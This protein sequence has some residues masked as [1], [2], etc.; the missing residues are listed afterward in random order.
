MFVASPLFS[1]Y[2]SGEDWPQKTV[3]IVVG[4]GP[5][6]S[7]DVMARHLAKSM[8]KYIKH[9]VIVI[10]KTGGDATLNDAYVK[11]QPADGLHLAS[12]TTTFTLNLQR[13]DVD[14]SVSDFLLVSRIHLDPFVF[15]VR[16]GG[17]YKT[18][19]D[20]VKDAKEKLGRLTV[21]GFTSIGGQRVAQI[22]FEKEA[23]IKCKWMAFKAGPEAIVTLMGGNAD[24]VM[25]NA[26][27]IR[28]YKDKVK[29]VAH[30]SEKPL[31]LAPDI[32]SFKQLGYS[33]ELTRYHWRGLVVRA[34][35]PQPIVEKVH[36]LITKA[37][38]DSEFAEFTKKQ[39]LIDGYLPLDKLKEF[40]QINAKKDK[41]VLKLLNVEVK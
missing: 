7:F 31:I 20:F 18:L 19:D 9:P 37:T 12:E 3:T 29:A 21:A 26:D 41:E 28:Q 13:K 17:P 1:A 14:M 15:F 10:N 27:Y 2:G 16:E 33:N 39:G 34:E 30:T 22:L 8:E 36:E 11:A 40:V 5:G 24:G 35:T 32:P 38:R 4:S 23:G 25:A 6:S